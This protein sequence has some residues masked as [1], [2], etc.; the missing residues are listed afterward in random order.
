MTPDD[1][2]TLHDIAALLH[3][4]HKTLQNRYYVDKTCLPPPLNV[5]GQTRPIW[6]TADIKEW[7]ENCRQSA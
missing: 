7:L 6:L 3:V 4:S 2:L 5:P 1:T